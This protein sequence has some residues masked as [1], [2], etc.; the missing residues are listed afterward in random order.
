MTICAQGRECL[1]GGVID[2]EMAADAAGRMVRRGTE[3][4]PHHYPGV[5][6]DAFAV[7]P[8]HVHG[9]IVLTGPGRPHGTGQP[10]GLPLRGAVSLGTGIVG[11]GPC[12]CPDRPGSQLSLPDVVHR[13]RSYTTAQYRRGVKQHGWPPFPGRMWQRNYWEQVIRDDASLNRIRKTI[14]NNAARRGTDKLHPDATPFPAL[15]RC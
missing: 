5:G 1:L 10:R 15:G 6:I 12:A 3:E 14:A 11:A 4:L 13:F 9:V 8:N 2:G 7:M